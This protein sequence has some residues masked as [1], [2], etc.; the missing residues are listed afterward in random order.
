M[1]YWLAKEHLSHV[2]DNQEYNSKLYQ[3][4]KSSEGGNRDVECVTTVFM[5]ERDTIENN[6]ILT[7][8]TLCLLNK[9]GK[10]KINNLD[11]D[12]LEIRLYKLGASVSDY[13]SIENFNK[14]SIMI[15]ARISEFSYDGV[16][17][18]LIKETVINEINDKEVDVYDFAFFSNIKDKESKYF[19]LECFKDSY[20]EEPSFN[21]TLS[22]KPLDLSGEVIKGSKITLGGYRVNVPGDNI[23]LITTN[24]LKE[25]IYSVF[26][27]GISKF[28]PSIVW[29]VEEGHTE[30]VISFNVFNDETVT[31]VNGN[32]KIDIRENN[33]VMIYLTVNC[34]D[35]IEFLKVIQELDTLRVEHE[36]VK[37]NTEILSKKRALIQRIKTVKE[38]LE[39]YDTALQVLEY[40]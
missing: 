5:V 6:P 31:K 4:F 10:Y 40:L 8:Y 14:G 29:R 22:L 11:L 20:L 15:L 13:I 7:P 1:A 25:L 35:R 23:N 3:Y 27:I 21:L 9:D 38:K 12:N 18:G 37:S 33:N 28:N 32:N 30:G 19:T 17:L 2:K 36:D 16:K 39:N 24:K 26:C 34:T